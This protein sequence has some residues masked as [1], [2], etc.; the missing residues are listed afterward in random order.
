MKT[1]PEPLNFGSAIAFTQELL[2][3]SKIS[4]S[5]IATLVQTEDGARGFFVT[6]LT[7][8]LADS[9]TQEIIEGLRSHSEIVSELL[10]KNL[11]MS[12]AQ[13]LYH[14]RRQDEEMAK[15]SQRVQERTVRLI[16]LLNLDLVYEKSQQLVAS[17]NA[18]SGSYQAFLERWNYDAEQ[19]QAIKAAINKFLG[20]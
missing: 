19:K 6:Y 14:H 9:P 5:E 10:I 12:T 4:A 3:Q 16:K 7:S 18:D 8:D 17:I 20:E 2:T 13:E 1:I 15:S 11:A